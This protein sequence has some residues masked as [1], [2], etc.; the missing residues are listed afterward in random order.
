MNEPALI[1]QDFGGKLGSDMDG[2]R[3]RLIKGGSW[4]R[5]RIVSVIPADSMIAAKVYLSHVNLIYPPNN[6]VVRILGQGLEV[7][8]AYSSAIEQVLGHPEL[9]DWEFVLALEADNLPPQDGI[10]NLV[11]DLETHPELAAVGGLYFTKGAG[12]VAQIWGDTRDPVV[13]FRPQVPMPDTIQECVGTGMGF[14]MYRLSMFKDPKL[15]RPWFVTQKGI[16]GVGT[17][18][19]YFW[20]DA[21]KHGYRCAVDTRIK[22][23]HLELG[24]GIVW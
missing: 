18:D 11:E 24:T 13:N 19:L 23:G 17:Q 4:K 14:T 20:G 8:H 10:L 2:T 21:R 9:K 5:Q 16:A 12:G 6:G 7:G 3:A 22:V 15:R 1:I